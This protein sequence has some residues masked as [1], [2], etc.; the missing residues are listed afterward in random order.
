MAKPY[1]RDE[2]KLAMPID[3]D[4]ANAANVKVGAQGFIEGIQ[5]EG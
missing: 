1:L 2:S 5:S 3:T 4:D